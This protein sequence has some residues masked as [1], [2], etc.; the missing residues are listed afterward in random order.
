MLSIQMLLLLMATLR[1]IACFHVPL[2]VVHQELN[3]YLSQKKALLLTLFVEL[4]ISLL[5]LIHF[6]AVHYALVCPQPPPTATPEQIRKFKE[7]TAPS[8]LKKRVSIKGK[9]VREAQKTFRITDPNQFLEAG[10]YLHVHVHP[11]R[12][13]SVF[14]HPN[15][16]KGSKENW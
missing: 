10:T 16:T 3:T 7:V 12:S 15:C 14:H 13:S 4:W 1:I 11:D 2:T 9:T 5:Y 8:V 6:G